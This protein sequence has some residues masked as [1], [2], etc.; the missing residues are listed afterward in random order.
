MLIY[1]ECPNAPDNVGASM[2]LLTMSSQC[3]FDRRRW[4]LW[5]FGRTQAL[6]RAK[7][8]RANSLQIQRCAVGKMRVLLIE[9][10][11]A[12]AHS[13]EL[14]LESENFNVFVTDLGEERLG[15]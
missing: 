1:M 6:F 12:T 9:D 13:I 15:A 3:R 14:M 5:Q 2:S 4:T 8:L 10:D 11:S 7:A